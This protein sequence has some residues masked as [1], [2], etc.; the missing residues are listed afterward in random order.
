MLFVLVNG[1]MLHHLKRFWYSLTIPPLLTLARAIFVAD[2]EILLPK[3]T[4]F[5]GDA[6]AVVVAAAMPEDPRIKT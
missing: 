3:L 1:F 6:S 4:A 2:D 5:T